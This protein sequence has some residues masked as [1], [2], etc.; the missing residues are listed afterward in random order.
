MKICVDILYDNG[1]RQEYYL[2][3]KEQL[4]EEDADEAIEHFTEIYYEA[5]KEDVPAS[6]KLTDPENGAIIVVNIKKVSQL[7]MYKS[8]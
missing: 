8:V 7:R 6:L 2:G 3:S 1:V 4:N 5:F